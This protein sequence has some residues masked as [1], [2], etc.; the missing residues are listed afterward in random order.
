MVD[1]MD[2]MANIQI[3]PDAYYE[4]KLKLQEKLI[5]LEESK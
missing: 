1:P 3:N 2:V 4:Q 5:D